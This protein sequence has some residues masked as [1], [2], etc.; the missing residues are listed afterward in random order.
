MMLL[1]CMRALRV[2]LLQWH[3]LV[4]EYLAKVELAPV[5]VISSSCA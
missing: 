3:Y 4:D 1:I 5:A 2:L